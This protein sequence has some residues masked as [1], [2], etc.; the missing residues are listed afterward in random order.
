M[1]FLETFYAN[2]FTVGALIPTIFNFFL[3][4]LF[5]SIKEKSRSTFHIGMSML[6]LA[7]FNLAYLVAGSFYHPWAAYHRWVTTGVI[8]LIETHFTFF[9]YHI[10]REERTPAARWL[11]RGMY[12]C[13]LL[14]AVF[15][16]ASTV[17]AGKVFIASAHQW[18]FATEGASRVVGVFILVYILIFV[19]V[20]AWKLY[21]MR[22]R[23]FGPILAMSI[24]Y[25]VSGIV[26]TI[27]N[28][29]SRN[30]VIERGLYQVIWDLFIIFGF[31][32]IAIL[33]LNYTEDR[34]SFMAKIVG[35]SMVTMLVILQGFSYYS[36]KDHEVAY[37]AA[38]SVKT[39]LAAETGEILPEMSYAY[40]V[41][42][43]G[44]TAPD[45]I[46]GVMD[47]MKPVI[48][49]W[50]GE[51]YNAA[52]RA[53]LARIPG[54]EFEKTVIDAVRNTPSHCT[55]YR[56]FILTV[57]QNA[58]GD[59]SAKKETVL[60]ALDRI[61]R[62][63]RYHRGKI[64]A[65]G[66]DSFREEVVAYTD[67][68]RED[69]YPFAQ[70]LASHV[71]YSGSEGAALR[72]EVLAF[73]APMDE[74]GTRRYR[75]SGDERFVSFIHVDGGGEWAFEAGFPYR[76]YR[77]YLHPAAMKFV[78]ALF[79]IMVFVTLGYGIFFQ[80]V[81]IGPLNE[82]V[83]GL[84]EVRKGNLGVTIPVRKEDEV[85]FMVRSFNT[86]VEGLGD[87]RARLDSYADELEEMVAE[88]TRELQASEA[89]YKNILASIGEGYYEVDLKGNVTFVNDSIARILGYS[90]EEVLAMNYSQFM[91]DNDVG[92]KIFQI[93]NVIYA[94]GEPSPIFDWKVLRKDGTV[95]TTEGT[96]SL[97][98]DSG[99]N[100]AGFRGILRDMTEK[101][102]AEEA[103]NRSEKKFQAIIA[104]IHEGIY[105]ADLAGNFTFV[106]D[107]IAEFF[108]YSK[109][110]ML[111]VN[112]SRIVP[113]ESVQ[114]VF[115]IYHEVYITG[116]RKELI[117]FEIVRRDGRRRY[118][119]HSI[120][121][122]TAPDGTKTGFRGVSR[123]ITA[124]KKAEEA[125]VELD[126]Q[127]SRFFANISHEI[128]TPLTL[129]L[130]PIESVIQGDYGK[131][132]SADFFRSLHKNG[133][134][135]LK[136]INDLLD[137]SKIEAG[138]MNLRVQ[139][140]DAVDFLMSFLRT[141]RSA[142]GAKRVAIRFS[143]PQA[144]LMIWADSDKLEKIVMNIFSNALKY[145][146]GGGSITVS[147]KADGDVCRIACEDTGE[148]VPPES[149]GRIFDRFGQAGEGPGGHREGTGIG[150]A[151][152]REFALLH[153][154]DIRV[155][156]RHKAH[157]PENHGSVF[158]VSLPLGKKH[159]EYREDAAFIESGEIES[160]ISDH[161]RIALHALQDPG[162]ESRTEDGGGAD[163]GVSEDRAVT[164]LVVDD[165]QEMQSFIGFLLGKEYRLLFA[166]NGEEG[167]SAA[168]EHR[169]DLIV[170]DVMMPVMDG[171]EMTRLLKSDPALKQIPVLMITAKAE[172][173]NKI[174]GLEHGADDYL[175]KPFN[176][177][178]L[179]V[180][181]HSLLRMYE[182]Q[183]LISARN[184]EIE[185]ELDMARLIL[186]R[187]LPSQVPLVPGIRTH[188]V[189]MPMDKVG[190]DFYDLY[191]QDGRLYFFIADVSGHGLHGAFLSLIAKMA[192]DGARE[193]SAPPLALAAV[194]RAVYRSTVNSN[195]VTAFYGVLDV[196][197]R[198]VRYS[199]AG[200]PAQILHRRSTEEFIELKTKGMPLGWFPSVRLEEAEVTLRAGDRLLIFTDGITECLSE[201]KELFGEE[202]LMD[203]MRRGAGDKADYFSG[204]LVKEL[205]SFR[206]S[207]RFNDD[208]SFIVI[209]AEV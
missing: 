90:L 24:T 111:N 109:D 147:V 78:W 23:S 44:K 99:G 191:E 206:G 67:R 89:R 81:L 146:E 165:N 92:K 209:D 177:K 138:R 203:C 93:F 68:H 56:M 48:G 20:M 66:D 154:G 112:F 184:L 124:R 83:H 120:E 37:D 69:F 54:G 208:L 85:G 127:K 190:G 9:I 35:I 133:I 168:R 5:L 126:R 16:Y 49:R 59:G 163:T 42:T 131:N 174:E 117:V 105:E 71:R 130:S 199:C 176:S 26:P 153:G 200:H 151:L 135:L 75:E 155:E 29:L 41:S 25:L 139:E 140:I 61:S 104:T 152:A 73:I 74:P 60:G 4:Y 110:E 145:T 149:L 158:T 122:I 97:I 142:A 63:V 108:G 80:G 30:G 39:H 114:S 62:A 43:G 31:F 173:A 87:A 101:L 129:M 17:S 148:G 162:G 1:G 7:V 12:A 103:L 192:L 156:S 178:E 169:P 193:K 187:L 185:Y 166:S 196:A 181:I 136:L 186:E 119:E 198:R 6:L 45:R 58:S 32:I 10:G 180:R 3:A 125:L 195:F 51:L 34:T 205:A 204:R 100:P 11:F 179:L 76:G 141:V 57:L 2:F 91:P 157:Y 40:R 13:S 172:L 188:A 128:R 95:R 55:A 22:G 38:H 182:Y 46:Y 8:L 64:E 94:S 183:R 18:D 82:L 207:D 189:C 47:E 144:P 161:A 143:Q 15:F 102:E 137:F 72:D 167:L 36:F 88:R 159:L 96:A 65:M 107:A 134:R 19:G 150:L 132:I 164:L 86:M 106:N 84:E 197:S 70:V 52:L 175:T 121:L 170:T 116:K 115:E 118:A 201:A 79:I 21:D 123:D 27:A 202:R 33:Y 113:P 50:R 14:V 98:V 194:N 28:I 171:Y 77:A 53:R 160:A